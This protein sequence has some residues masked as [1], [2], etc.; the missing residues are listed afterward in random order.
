MEGGDGLVEGSRDGGEVGG[1]GWGRMEGLG[2]R[3][4]GRLVHKIVLR[5]WGGWGSYIGHYL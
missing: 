3:R 1:T 5:G 4:M 2:A